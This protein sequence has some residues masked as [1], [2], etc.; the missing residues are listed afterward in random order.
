MV[1]ASGPVAL[2]GAL[3][4]EASATGDGVVVG[5]VT[6]TTSVTL[7]SVAVFVGR[8]TST[9]VGALG[10][11]ESVSFELEGADQFRFGADLFR[12]RWQFNGAGPG[13]PMPMPGPGPVT[14]TMEGFGQIVS[15]TCDS[16]GNCTQCDENGNCFEVG[17]LMAPD[18]TCDQFGN[19]FPSGGCPAGAGCEGPGRPGTLTAALW[20]RG[21]NTLAGSVVTA[22]G[23]TSDLPPVVDLGSGVEIVG[24]RTALVGRTVPTAGATDLV[25]SASVRLLV[26]AGNTDDGLVELINRFDLP[27]SV[28]GR[29]VDLA[30]LRF[31]LP[32]LFARAAILTPEGEHVIRE[33]NEAAADRLQV[34]V[35]PEA[36]VNGHVFIRLAL[37]FAPPPPGRELVLYEEPR[38]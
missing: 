37:P 6:N 2:D 19:C 24:T 16:N 12:E 3:E 14:T 25:D 27:P 5:T 38:G 28:D 18:M 36:V 29:P 11:G 31:D 30:R 17:V 7:E 8:S 10:P 23:W 20:D 34:A 15:E 21:S 9:D 26:G 22:V 32:A 13:G 33:G 1:R 35:P 4:V